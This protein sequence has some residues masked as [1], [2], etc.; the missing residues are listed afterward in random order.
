MIYDICEEYITN[1]NESGLKELKKKVEQVY[2]IQLKQFSFDFILYPNFKNEGDYSSLDFNSHYIRH[3]YIK[4]G[5]NY[6]SMTKNGIVKIDKEKCFWDITIY[7]NEITMF[8]NGYYLDINKNEEE[9]ENVIG[10]QYMI[11]WNFNKVNEYY[12]FINLEK[13]NNNILSIEGN[14]VKVNKETAENNEMF[15][16]I[17]VLEEEE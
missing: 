12:Y 2:N 17:D 1:Y 10:F 3:V 9:K 7:D 5:D 16:L 4:N 11:R 6:L 13:K 8:S 15:L 14:E